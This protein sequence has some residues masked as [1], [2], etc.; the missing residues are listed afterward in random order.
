MPADPTAISAL[1]RFH[2]GVKKAMD[3]VQRRQVVGLRENPGG[4]FA[5]SVTHSNRL[6]LIRTTRSK[7][8]S[9]M[10]V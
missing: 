2:K 7:F 4:T 1:P 3:P 6:E 10:W 5:L 8:E 9:S